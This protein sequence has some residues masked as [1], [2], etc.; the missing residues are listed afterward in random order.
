[1][2]GHREWRSCAVEVAA[3]RDYRGSQLLGFLCRLYTERA[4][5]G[6]KNGIKM[7]GSNSKNKVHPGSSSTPS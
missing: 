1:L 4:R 6:E 2:R 3:L 5:S 7:G